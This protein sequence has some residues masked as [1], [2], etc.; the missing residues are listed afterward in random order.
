MNL[1]V[2]ATFALPEF[3]G[4]AER[5]LTETASRLAARGHSVT[6]LTGRVGG[7]SPVEERQGVR[8]LRYPIDRR[9]PAFF[10]RSV[11]RGVQGL[12]ARADLV[13]PDL[14]HLHQYSS[15]LGALASRRLAGIPRLLSFH[16]PYHLEWLAGRLDGSPVGRP[17]PG[18][19]LI[20]AFIRA[21]DRRLVRSC[22]GLH[23]LSRFGLEQ[24]TDLDASAPARARIIPPGIDLERFRPARDRAERAEARR[25]AGLPADG[26]PLLLTVRRLVPRMGLTDLVAA[27]GRLRD[28]G[29]P[30]HLAVAG[31]G[32][33]GPSLEAQSRAAGLGSLAHWIGRVPEEALPD[34]YR[35]ADLFILPTRSLEGFG[36]STAE[37]LASGLPIV[38]TSAGAT[39]DLL[40]GLDGAVLVPPADPGALAAAIAGGLADPS[41]REAAGRA[42][43]AHAERILRWDTSIETLEAFMSELVAQG[44]PRGRPS[45]P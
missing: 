37:A 32:G 34:L 24:A 35:G 3:P 18:Q 10:H 36:M 39:P 16:A 6:L 41:A 25:A 9:N 13:R 31:Q 5:V 22:D 14:V 33:E 8:V 19:R 12:L 44:A 42:S 7:S 28:D 30:V 27:V 15:A 21:G 11:Q 43:R 2:V 40:G 1:L 38:A 29:I 45:S 23:V 26:V 4:G 20:A 17:S